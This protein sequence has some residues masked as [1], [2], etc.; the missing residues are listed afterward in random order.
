MRV[1]PEY[2]TELPPLAEQNSLD[3]SGKRKDWT[4]IST[5]LLKELSQHNMMNTEEEA[6]IPIVSVKES[7]R[8][9]PFLDD[10]PRKFLPKYGESKEQLYSLKHAPVFIMS[11][12]LL[13][14][15]YV[16]IV[17]GD[18]PHYCKMMQEL[19][20]EFRS[21]TSNC[22]SFCPSPVAGNLIEIL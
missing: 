18:Y 21:A 2:L 4:A 1:L 9:T 6:T 3:I 14:Q 22:A 10:A 13:T 7:V 15:V 12:T 20:E 17:D 11:A 8:K 5:N 19:Q 16:R